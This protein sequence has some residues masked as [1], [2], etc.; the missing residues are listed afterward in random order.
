MA[1]PNGQGVLTNIDLNDRV[2][3]ALSAGDSGLALDDD[4]VQIGLEQLLYRGRSVITSLDFGPRAIALPMLYI[5]DA[6]HFLGQFLAALSQAGEQQLTFDNATYILARYAG[7]SGRRQAGFKPPL[8]WNYLLHLVAKSPWFQDA[9]AATATPWNPITV[10]AGQAAN[11]TYAGSVWAEPV[12][13]YHVPVGNAVVINSIQLK[14]TMSGQFL[15]VNF[16]SATPIPA[17]TVRDVVIDCAAMTAV[18]TQTGEAYDVS[19]SF[20]FLY[21]PAGQSNAFTIITTPASG[22]TSGCTLAASWFPR[23]Q[24]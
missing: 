22:S 5:E 6:T 15:T 24:L 14:N 13:T 2:N 18:C 8:S 19:G 16:L 10:D 20:P 1:L 12:W 11:I 4:N 9:A 21:P 17:G 7:A 3:T 23:W